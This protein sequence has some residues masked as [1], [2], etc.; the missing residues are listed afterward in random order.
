MDSAAPEIELEDW[1]DFM[2]SVMEEEEEE[3]EP[4]EEENDATT[5]RYLRNANCNVELT[6][7]VVDD[8]LLGILKEEIRVISG[9]V[10]KQV[11]PEKG[12]LSEVINLNFIWSLS[13]STAIRIS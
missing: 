6:G 9:R 2:T 3:E 4:D 5:W 7:N 8:M 13:I 11:N 10:L 1:L 12:L